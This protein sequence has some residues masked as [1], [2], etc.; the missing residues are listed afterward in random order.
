MYTKENLLNDLISECYETQWNLLK[1]EFVGVQFDANI[2]TLHLE[3]TKKLENMLDNV[4][5]IEWSDVMKARQTIYTCNR[6]ITTFLINQYD[7]IGSKNK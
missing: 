2:L 7:K 5:G 6:F 3:M 4:E 1:Y